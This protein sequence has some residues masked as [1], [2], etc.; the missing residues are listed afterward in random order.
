MMHLSKQFLLCCLAVSSFAACVETGSS[1]PVSNEADTQV[2]SQAG[3]VRQDFAA[4]GGQIGS[5][6][7]NIVP[8]ATNATACFQL[9]NGGVTFF[10]N[11]TIDLNAYPYAIV[12]GNISGGICDAPNW[13]LTGVSMGNSI[14]INGTHTG[15]GACASTIS[16]VGNFGAPD[17]YAG[18]YGFNGANNSFPHRTMFLGYNRSCP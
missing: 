11:A 3:T 6:Q 8:F 16:I 15:A 9:N 10:I 12:G 4:N 14:S 17:D 5:P 1:Q 2:A 7:A 13:A 18:T